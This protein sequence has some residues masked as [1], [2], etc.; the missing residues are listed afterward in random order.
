MDGHLTCLIHTLADNAD[1]D[2]ALELPDTVNAS[3]SDGA[4]DKLSTEVDGKVVFRAVIQGFNCLLVSSVIVC[5]EVHRSTS[6]QE[7][8]DII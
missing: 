6:V 4:A 8:H 5:G 1:L 2:H 3:G 7:S